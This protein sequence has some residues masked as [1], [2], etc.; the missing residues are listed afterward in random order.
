M[1]FYMSFE[2]MRAIINILY[3]IWIAFLVLAYPKI[4]NLISEKTIDN[5]NSP[6]VEVIVLFIIYTFL[7]LAGLIVRDWIINFLYS[8]VQE[9]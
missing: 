4:L 7:V 1:K 9:V 3:F 2:D 6:L 5:D 8:C